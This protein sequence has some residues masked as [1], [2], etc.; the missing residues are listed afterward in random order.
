MAR[1]SPCTRSGRPRSSH[2]L[3]TQGCIPTHQKARPYHWPYILILSLP[4]SFQMT[5]RIRRF[6]VQV[7]QHTCTI[8]HQIPDTTN[9][10]KHKFE[11]TCVSRVHRDSFFHTPN[12][13]NTDQMGKTR[14]NHRSKTA[15]PGSFLSKFGILLHSHNHHKFPGT[16]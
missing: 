5:E 16:C 13:R 4:K 10:C 11:G 15:Q 3:R 8:S 14:T 7:L 1:R 6:M 2:Q 9:R 12:L